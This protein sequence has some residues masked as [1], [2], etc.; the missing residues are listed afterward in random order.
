MANKSKKKQTPQSESLPYDPEEPL[1]HGNGIASERQQEH[2]GASIEPFDPVAEEQHLMA[3]FKTIEREERI[4]R[5]KAKLANARVAKTSGFLDAQQGRDQ[6]CTTS[7]VRSCSELSSNSDGAPTGKRC[8]LDEGKK[9]INPPKDYYGKSY[10]EFVS[11]TQALKQ[12]F[13]VRPRLYRHNYQ[14]ILYVR[15]YLQGEVHKA[16][17]RWQNSPEND[18]RNFG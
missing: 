11:F 14:R 16:W 4:V 12:V 1:D 9:L 7:R 18:I 8:G 5:L 2:S 13:D 17:Y 15:G 6:D 10:G 3:Q